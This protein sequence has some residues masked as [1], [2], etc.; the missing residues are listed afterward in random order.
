MRQIGMT[1]WRRI[2]MILAILL[3]VRQACAAPICIVPAKPKG[4][5]DLTCQLIQSGLPHQSGPEALRIAHMPGGV[6]AITFNAIITRRNAEPDTLVAFSGGSLFN[7]AQGKFGSYSERDV[8]WLAGIGLDY[9]V[10]IVRADSPFATLR[11]LMLAVKQD[12]AKFVFGGSGT[13]HGQDW[14]KLALI[15]RQAGISESALRFVGFEGGGE[16]NAALQ[17]RHVSVVSGDASEAVGLIRA[18]APLR[19]LTVLSNRRL[20]G[21]LSEVPT[22]TESGYAVEWSNIRGVYMGARV[23]ESDYLRWV[24][25]FNR[26][27][28]QPDFQRRREEM[29]LA[30]YSS[31]GPELDTQ[32]RELVRKYGALATQFSNATVPSQ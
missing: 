4:G 1:A 22:A 20:Q 12:P 31:T 19:V 29:G 15:A 11:D 3:T 13:T 6:G 10:L 8:R 18:G 9:G 26:L 25:T 30:P 24:A 17:D 28:S 7:I 16:A 14:F 2:G 5:F 32:V 21:I 23:S 27:L